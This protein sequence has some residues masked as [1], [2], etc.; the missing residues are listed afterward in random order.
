MES[1]TYMIFPSLAMV[2]QFKLFYTTFC[3]TA[4]KESHVR[5]PRASGF[6]YWASDFCFVL[7]F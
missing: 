7:C 6:C 5:L 2:D 4:C 3:N 1:F